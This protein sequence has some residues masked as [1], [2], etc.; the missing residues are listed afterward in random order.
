M[1]TRLH[2]VAAAYAASN[3]PQQQDQGKRDRN[4]AAAAWLTAWLSAHRLA[5]PDL[6]GIARR[7]TADGWLIGAASATSLV[8]GQP[9]DLGGWQPGG[10]NYNPGPG[11]AKTAAAGLVSGLPAAGVAYGGWIASAYLNAMGRTLA[12]GQDNGLTVDQLATGLS[13]VLQS[14]D[15]ATGLALNVLTTTSATAAQAVYTG[16]QVDRWHWVTAEDEKV[17]PLCDAN[18]AAGPVPIGD[19]FPSGDT[20]PPAHP[21]CRC[22]GIPD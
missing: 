4:A 21:N 22:A 2:Q 20:S 11:L 10:G 7:I 16:H 15:V 5:F 18:E 12:T 9:V 13:G 6:T 19:P 8:T 1:Q 17:C 14:D 3:P